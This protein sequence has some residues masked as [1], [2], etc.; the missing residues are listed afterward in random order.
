MIK[1]IVMIICLFVCVGCSQRGSIE[2][3]TLNL[4]IAFEDIQKEIK[5]QGWNIGTLNET[6]I[7]DEKLLQDYGIQA[8]DVENYMVKQ[9]VIRADCGEI[10]IF[11]LKDEDSSKIEAAVKQRVATLKSEMNL[12]P[13]QLTCLEQYQVQQIGRYYVFVL[14]DD[15]QNVIQY[16]SSL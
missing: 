10:A 1:K 15:A 7:N 8:S 4:E 14:G 2:K 12:L 5:E 3:N 6:F 11:H 16:I 9:A 13:V